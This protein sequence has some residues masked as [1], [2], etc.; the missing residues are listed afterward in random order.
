MLYMLIILSM[1]K[2]Y[3]PMVDGGVSKGALLLVVM[4]AYKEP[5]FKSKQRMQLF[6]AQRN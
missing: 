5:L 1:S 6:S 2:L 3:D 4:S